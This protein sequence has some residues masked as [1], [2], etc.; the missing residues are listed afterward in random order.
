MLAY[1]QVKSSDHIIFYISG[2][3]GYLFWPK[4]NK[5]LNMG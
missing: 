2:F 3:H 5:S 4:H 1:N